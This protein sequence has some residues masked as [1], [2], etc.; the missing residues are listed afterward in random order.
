MP[1]LSEVPGSPQ[2]STLTVKDSVVVPVERVTAAVP[3]NVACLFGPQVV[4]W[5]MDSV[6]YDITFIRTPPRDRRNLSSH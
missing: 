6:L 2:S 1:N 3:V 5:L 4:L